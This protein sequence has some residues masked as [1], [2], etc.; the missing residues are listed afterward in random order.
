MAE[1]LPGNS[2]VIK[3]STGFNRPFFF[4]TTGQTVSVSLSKNGG[5][6]A[7][8]AGAVSELTVGW[9]N[10]L[11]SSAD[12]N[13]SGILAYHATASSGGPADFCD[14]VQTNIFTDLSM[15][16]SGFV[17]ISSNIKQN[18]ALPGFTF[19][20]VDSVTGAPKTFLSVTAQR[21]LAGAGFAPCVNAVT[22]LG[23]GLYV[24]NLA[25]SDLNSTFVTLRFTATAASDLNIPFATQP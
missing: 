16:A 12:T 21:S 6:F 17:N 20:M 1:T 18:V 7:G 25:A 3:Q 4:G 11:L 8:A 10:I 24:I 22:E 13:T 2:F 19:L 15:N 23:N 5:A 9:Y 14:Y